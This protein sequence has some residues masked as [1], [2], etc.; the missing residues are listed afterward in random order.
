MGVFPLFEI[1][2]LKYNMNVCF[3]YL[4]YI[5]SSTIGV[6]VSIVRDTLS[7]V[8]YVSMFT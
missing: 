2:N 5:I 3:H 4:I 6:S 1:Y 7:K 8:Q